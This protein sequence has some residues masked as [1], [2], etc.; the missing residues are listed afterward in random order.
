M[1]GLPERM[2]RKHFASDHSG[3]MAIV[4]SFMMPALLTI[5]GGAVDMARWVDANSRTRNALDA[6]VLAGARQLRV[7][8]TN[9]QGALALAKAIYDDNITKRLVLS[10]DTVKF[11]LTDDQQGVTAEGTAALQT[12][13]LNMIG[14]K[15]MPL[16]NGGAAEFPVAKIGVGGMGGSNLEVAMVL[17]VTGSMC[18]DG[19]GPCT[20]G[21]KMDGL[22]TA[23]K[24]LINIAISPDQSKYRTRAAI[25][26]FST[27]IRVEP[28]NDTGGIMKSLTNM[29]PA[30]SGWYKM[31]IQETWNTVGSEAD[32][33]WQCLQ[34]QTNQ[35]FGWAIK[36]CVTDRFTNDL[37]FDFTDEAPGSNR[38][39]NAHDGGRMPLSWDSSDTPATTQL[40]KVS[41]DP[42][43]FWNYDNGACYEAA[44]GNVVRPL[45]SDRTALSA[46]IDGLEAYGATGGAAG[47]AWGWYML[48]PKWSGIWAGDSMPG[49][50]GD[51]TTKQSNGA[52]VL[53]KVAVIMSD[54]L[55]NSYRGWKEQDP[56]Y[57]SDAA[58]QFCT[59]MKAAGI[60][61][62]AVGF[63]LDQ[64][65]AAD[66]ARARNTLQSCGT[67]V[68]HFYD[69][70]NVSQ[71]QTAFREIALNLSSVYLTR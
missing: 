20:G 48:S 8:P 66:Q 57:V 41:S 39:L 3:N 64:L 59:N 13:L 15:S 26:P 2:P 5:G 32:S 46:A 38:W 18:D 45:S 56:Q 37:G 36:P 30:W 16:L 29:D 11:K 52:P 27:R 70:L 31:C 22:K 55:Y 51:L 44:E 43:T 23:A 60:E 34:Y 71:L 53:R 54:G 47:T 62:Y 12:T 7:D 24:D 63:A 14:I 19:T 1:H 40:G 65:P 50:Y 25:I 49:G 61:I 28:D 58:V 9:S 67:D 42:A 68:K 21:A 6:A 10:T 69:T 4:F 33:G 35:Y 17:D